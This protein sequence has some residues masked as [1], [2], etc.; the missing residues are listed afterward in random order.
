MDVIIDG[1]CRFCLGSTKLLRRMLK[2]QMNVITQ[3]DLKYADFQNRFDASD[4]A[5]DSIKL[6]KGDKLLMKSKAISVLMV[7]A[8]WYFQPLRILFLL[9]TFLL[10]A[11]YDLIAKNRYLWNKGDNCKII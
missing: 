8:H 2:V 1:D 5:I 6:I 11:V 9:P 7:E 3:Y 10:D 4:W